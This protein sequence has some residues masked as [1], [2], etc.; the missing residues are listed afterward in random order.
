MSSALIG[1]LMSPNISIRC[2]LDT[3][4][5]IACQV[6][7]GAVHRHREANAAGVVIGLGGGRAATGNQINQTSIVRAVGG[8][9]RPTA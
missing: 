5:R 7:E 4:Q 3:R 6:G 1:A 8:R 9:A 2:A